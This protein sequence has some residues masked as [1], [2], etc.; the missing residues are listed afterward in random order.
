MGIWKKSQARYGYYKKETGKLPN[1]IW[2]ERTEY[3]GNKYLIANKSGVQGNPSEKY[4]KTK[5][6]AIKFMRKYKQIH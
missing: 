6:D 1:I 3:K 2:M 4:F 5:T